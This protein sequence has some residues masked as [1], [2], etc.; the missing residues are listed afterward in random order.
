MVELGAPSIKAVYMPLWD[1]W[2]ALEGCHRLRAAY[3]LGL[4]PEIE[5]I[6]YSDVCVTD[7]AL[8]LDLD[9]P[10]MTVAQ[11][12]DSAYTR[13]SLFFGD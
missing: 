6:G 11:L 5:E 3:A 10:G 12:C 4:V 9:N 1:A 2:A 7:P 13:Q 8:Y